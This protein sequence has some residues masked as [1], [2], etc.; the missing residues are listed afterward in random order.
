MKILHWLPI[1]PRIDYKVALVSHKTQV[2]GSPNYLKDLIE[3][4]N[5]RQHRL[6]HRTV[7][8][9][10]SFAF[11][12]F[13]YAAPII[14]NK[15]P[16]K[17]KEHGKNMEKFKKDLKSYFFTEGFEYKVDSIINYTPS[18]GIYTNR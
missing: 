17:V 7:E 1:G 9:G 14:Y 12:A 15:I 16:K 4:S 3:I 5:S 18:A 6:R 13:F 8:G 11:R 10:H 2:Y